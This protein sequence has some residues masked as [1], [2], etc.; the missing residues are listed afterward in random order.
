MQVLQIIKSC[1]TRRTNQQ[2]YLLSRFPVTTVDGGEDQLSVT[3]KAGEH[4]K[5]DSRGAPLVP[6]FNLQ[7]RAEKITVLHSF[8]SP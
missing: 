8:T 2:L 7:R 6:G 5:T 1:S 4:N 3:S